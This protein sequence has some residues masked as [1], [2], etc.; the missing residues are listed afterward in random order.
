MQIC[1]RNWMY[2]EL[3]FLFFSCSSQIPVLEDRE[4]PGVEGQSG[5]DSATEER[6]SSQDSVTNTQSTDSLL[7]TVKIL[8][9]I[10]YVNVSLCL[11]GSSNPVYNIFRRILKIQLFKRR[12]KSVTF[13]S[14][15]SK[16]RN[17]N[18]F[19]SVILNSS[20]TDF[21]KA[22]KD[23]SSPTYLFFIII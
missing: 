12:L 4:A 23:V 17:C 7:G 5:E 11:E 8:N 20:K 1:K 13:L 21:K 14:T 2:A 15:Q 22:D 10:F 6:R 19:C 9:C 18:T 3:F 16:L